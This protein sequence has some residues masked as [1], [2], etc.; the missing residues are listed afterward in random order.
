MALDDDPFDFQVTKAE[1]VRVFRGGREVV[2]VAGR[3]AEKLVASL[4]VDDAT[5]QQLLARV[6]GNYR[7]GNE[8]SGRMR[9]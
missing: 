5:D 6:T 3:A 8:R 4:G 7:R 9:R 1:T 2:T